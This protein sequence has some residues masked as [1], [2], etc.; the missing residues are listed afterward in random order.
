MTPVDAKLHIVQ[1]ENLFIFEQLQLEEALIRTSSDNYCIINHGTKPSVVMGIS[2][3]PED[4]ID[5]TEYKKRPVPVI[6]RFSGG[7]TVVVDPDTIFVT[8]LFQKNAMPTVNCPKTVLEWS[9]KIYK[10]AF[11]DIPILLRENDYIIGDKKVGGNAQYFV[12]N[13]WLHHT[14]FLFDYSNDLM[15][16][17]KMPKKKP[18]YRENRDHTSFCD[19]LRAHFPTKETFIN[20]L[21]QY[22]A[23]H[24]SCMQITHQQALRHST[25]EHRKS[26]HFVDILGM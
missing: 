10:N 18:M 22:L 9:E 5:Y 21:V 16:L 4:L 19:K 6:K 7:G 14:S 2:G 11:V 3:K 20:G 24:F 1:T 12:K 15:N 13:A 25:F 23:S 26:L 8:F 17:L